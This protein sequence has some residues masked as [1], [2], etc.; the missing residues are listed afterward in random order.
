MICS[1]QKIVQ[2]LI[3]IPSTYNCYMEWNFYREWHIMKGHKG[4]IR[5]SQTVQSLC[6]TIEF[7]TR[8]WSN[9]AVSF[10]FIMTFAS[11]SS[12]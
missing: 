6:A 8:D 4:W 10:D 12:R 9:A 3:N 5:G 2:G 11:R 7:F 1:C